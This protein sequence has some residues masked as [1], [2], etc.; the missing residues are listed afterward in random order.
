MR[1]IL[2]IAFVLGLTLAPTAGAADWSDGGSITDPAQTAQPLDVAVDAQGEAGFVWAGYTQD[3]GDAR[4]RFRRRRFGEALGNPEA[5]FGGSGAVSVR[6]GG[7]EFLLT[8]ATPLSTPQQLFTRS[9]RGGIGGADT[10]AGA[11]PA[12]R[13]CAQDAAL[14]ANGRALAVYGLWA[15]GGTPPPGTPGPLYARVRPAPG[16]A[17]E[18]PVQIGQSERFGGGVS[19]ELDAEGRGFV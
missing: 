19:G 11:A 2:A 10:I 15:G 1:R 13:I 7:D 12:E 5:L 16:Q 3:G 8:L 6:A 14:S 4:P 17:F 18:P 9:F